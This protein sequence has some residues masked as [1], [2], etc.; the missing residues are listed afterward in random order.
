[1]TFKVTITVVKFKD[2]N[3]S[4]TMHDYVKIANFGLTGHRHTV[5]IEI[6][7]SGHDL[8]VKY[9]YD[10]YKNTLIYTWGLVLTP[11]QVKD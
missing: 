8:V 11:S 6:D 5:K 10:K 4:W 3:P 7:P 9:I 1:M 2:L